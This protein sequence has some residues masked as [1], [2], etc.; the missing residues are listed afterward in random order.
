MGKFREGERVFDI[1]CGEYGNVVGYNG[2]IVEVLY[3]NDYASDS[4]IDT[5]DESELISA[6]SEKRETMVFYK[7][8]YAPVPGFYDLRNFDLTLREFRDAWRTQLYLRS[9]QDRKEDYKTHAPKAWKKALHT[10]AELSFMLYKR[11]KPGAD[12]A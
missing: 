9:V 2:N 12:L 10:S 11:L 8:D 4:L 6:A 5:A 1:Y 7:K 3:D